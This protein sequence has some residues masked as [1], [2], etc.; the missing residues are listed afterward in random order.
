MTKNFKDFAVRPQAQVVSFSN[1]PLASNFL[2]FNE[3]WDYMVAA[4][5]KDFKDNGDLDA[6]TFV[7]KENWDKSVDP[8]QSFYQMTNGGGDF[9]KVKDYL[10]VET[11]FALMRAYERSKKVMGFEV[12]ELNALAEIVSAAGKQNGM[13]PREFW[14]AIM[15]SE[16]SFGIDQIIDYLLEGEESAVA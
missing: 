14:D 5:R 7:Y 9:D 11:V 8:R 4:L 12:E 2:M 15:L 13:T 1:S 10:K 3:N 16:E 6:L